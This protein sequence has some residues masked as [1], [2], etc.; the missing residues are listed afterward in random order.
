MKFFAL[1]LSLL[2]LTVSSN[3]AVKLGNEV[4]VEKQ[5]K[6]L[7]GKRIGLI[8]NPSGVNSKFELTIDIL[9]SAP[10]VKLV[11]LFAPEHGIYGDIPA[12]D[13]VTNRVD[14]RTG[15]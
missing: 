3:A 5:F 11:T 2:L 12:G 14:V 15:L 1:I 7:V 9:R 4:L 8:T 13:K 10:D 6:P